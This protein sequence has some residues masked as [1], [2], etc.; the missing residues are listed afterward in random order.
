MD[1]FL[2]GRPHPYTIQGAAAHGV[3]PP[4]Y[5]QVYGGGHGQSM[6]SHNSH[7][8]PGQYQIPLYPPRSCA[9]A[10]N[11]PS[12]MINPQFPTQVQP[13]NP[14]YSNGLYYPD[15]RRLVTSS[16]NLRSNSNTNV[17]EDS[18]RHLS[19]APDSFSEHRSVGV[20]IIALLMSSTL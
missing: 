10:N 5:D 12:A 11:Y 3:P 4:S 14:A 18:N 13:H 7:Q 1:K 15:P 9:M 16:K 2:Q 8:P 19:E 20:V 17:T 6:L